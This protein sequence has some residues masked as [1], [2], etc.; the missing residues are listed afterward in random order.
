MDEHDRQAAALNEAGKIL[1]RE[2]DV[3]GY[4]RSAVR[5]LAVFPSPRRNTARAVRNRG[6]FHRIFQHAIRRMGS[7]RVSELFIA[8]AE[9]LRMVNILPVTHYMRWDGDVELTNHSLE[10]ARFTPIG[11]VFNVSEAEEFGNA[12]SER[13]RIT[14][15]LS[16]TRN[17]KLE[18][19][20]VDTVLEEM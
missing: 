20:Q 16:V 5:D 17:R 18:E 19:R 14:Y 7:E 11:T 3:L 6:R 15:E 1:R 2:F 9:D 10:P 4:A 8:D 12:A 13:D